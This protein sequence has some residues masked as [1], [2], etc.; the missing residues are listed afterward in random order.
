[1]G[2]PLR[3][4]EA[5]PGPSGPLY[6]ELLRVAE[7]VRWT[8]GT[9]PWER[10]DLAR[11]TTEL[12]AVVRVMAYSEQATFSATQRFMQAFSDDPDFSQ[13]ISVWFYEETRHPMVLLRWL[14][15]AGEVLEG[16]F[17]RRGRVSTPFIKSRPG[18]LV[19][20]VI[21]EMVAAEAYLRLA[22]AAPEPLL[23]ALASR[24]GADEGRH[25]ASF[26]AYARRAVEQASDPERERLDAL[27]VLHF[28]LDEVQSVS[29]PVNQTMEAL[30][31]LH[32]PD[33]E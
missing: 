9:V 30:Q 20:N 28:W 8:P 11:A 1:A 23:A 29:H 15:L 12:R 31:Q 24:I 17:V 2:A 10:F 19:T 6:A 33:P 16:D 7:S 4:P 3:A 18:T 5:S 13:W 26:Y 14:A 27:K 21:S 25:A 22:R 32:P